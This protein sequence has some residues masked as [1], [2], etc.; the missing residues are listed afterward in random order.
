M[1]LL[2]RGPAILLCLLA[3][4][5]QAFDF[6]DVAARA[7]ELAS[8]SYRKPDVRLPKDLTALSYDQYRDIRFRPDKSLWRG[9]GLPFEL[10]F[11]HPGMFYT[12]T[13]AINV[14]TRTGVRPQ[15]FDPAVFDYGANDI[16]RDGL[17][18]LGY[19]GFRA[20]Y[21]LN[22]KDYKD[23]L[24][25]FQGASYFRAL[26]KGQRYGLSARG[27]A[28]DTGLMSG[29]EF[30]AFTEFWVQAPGPT[31]KLLTVFALLDSRRATGAYRFQLRPGDST[32]MDVKLRVFL[33]E[34]IG[35]LGIAPLTSMFFFG[36]NQAARREDYRPEVHDSDGLMVDT[37][38]EWLWRPLVN[39]RR[40]LITSYTLVNPRGFGLMQRDRAFAHYEDLEAR[41]EQRPSAWV[42]PVGDWGAGRVE[43][44]QLPTPDETNDNIVAYWVPDKLPPPGQPLDLQ[45]Q[46]SWQMKHETVPALARVVQSRRGHGYIRELDDTLRFHVDFEGGVLPKIPADAK[47]FAGIWVGD[48]GELVER[49]VYRND[50]TGGWRVA[51]RI[52]RF[53]P[54]KPVEMR[55]VLQRAKETISETWSYILPGEP[56]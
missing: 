51:L 17:R 28:I 12:Q 7:R 1:K 55:S 47:L 56:E 26:G 39:P 31:D 43:L 29:E 15:R 19:A 49:Q 24:L 48:N 27:L 42:T 2:L 18:D 45:Y 46:L 50:A 25:V 4:P 34:P 37:G 32:V 5:A 16:D 8:E 44:L 40:L 22:H 52:R 3:A 6:E 35:K 33:R 14:I 53:D 11:F 36:E 13:V 23:E 10:Q 20:H 41:Y 38:E 9:A 21:P 30:P 54:D